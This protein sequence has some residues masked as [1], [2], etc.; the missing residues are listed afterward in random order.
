MAIPPV[1]VSRFSCE[2]LEKCEKGLWGGESER[3][4]SEGAPLYLGVRGQ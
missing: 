1:G 3:A 4:L 2:I